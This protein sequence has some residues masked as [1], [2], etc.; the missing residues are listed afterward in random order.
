MLVT[1]ENSSKSVAFIS[2]TPSNM[3]V[4]LQ[5][6]SNEQAG[7]YTIVITGTIFAATSWNQSV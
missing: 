7:N 3:T 5:T 6:N 4:L 1:P 2:F